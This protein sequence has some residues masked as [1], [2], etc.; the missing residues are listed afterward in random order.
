VAVNS[1]S[2]VVPFQ[3]SLD[4]LYNG[5]EWSWRNGTVLSYAS[6][7]VDVNVLE[8]WENPSCEVVINPQTTLVSYINALLSQ[9]PMAVSFS[10]K[11]MA[12]FKMTRENGRYSGNTL[13]GRETDLLNDAES[14]SK[15]FVVYDAPTLP[16]EH[17]IIIIVFSHGEYWAVSSKYSDLRCLSDSSVVRD[18]PVIRI[19]HVSYD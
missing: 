14:F 4:V 15:P 8:K 2:R 3:Y 13:M 12:F 16:R 17:A 18:W 11:M 7:P 9:A 19:R 6:S 5:I 1:H 10:T